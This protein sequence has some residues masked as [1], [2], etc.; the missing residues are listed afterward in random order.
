[1]SRRH[2]GL[3]L[4]ELLVVM[5]VIVVLI[6]LLIPAVQAARDGARRAQCVN[7]LKQLGIALS[8]YAGSLGVYPF[9]VGADADGA[10]PTYSS[11]GNRRYSMHS[12]IL[13][14]LEQGALFNALNFH[15]APSTPA[16]R[17]TR[18]R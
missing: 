10:V 11:T 16:R 9:G 3:T 15:V 4:I 5:T 14:H 7:N 18:R 17:G 2:R 1:M 12:Q 8:S 6:A 13:A